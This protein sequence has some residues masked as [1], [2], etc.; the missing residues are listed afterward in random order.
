MRPQPLKTFTQRISLRHPNLHAG[1]PCTFI[2]CVE[3]RLD[4]ISKSV[5]RAKAEAWS[6]YEMPTGHMAMLTMPNELADI[7]LGPAGTTESPGA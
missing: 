2:E 5:E 4:A 1:L 6:H 3:P 7:F